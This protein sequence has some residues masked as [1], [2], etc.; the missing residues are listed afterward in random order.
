MLDEQILIRAGCPAG[1]V[2]HCIAVSCT[3]VAI[4]ERITLV[5]VDLEL[6]RTGAL[7]HD[8]GRAR[9]HGLD[10]A[11]VGVELG[12]EIGLPEPVLTIIERHIGAGITANEAGR[13]G[14]PVKDYLPQTPEEKIVSYAD[15]L[16]KGDRPMSFEAALGRFQDILGPGHEGIG[17]FEQQHREIQAWMK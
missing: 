7:L 17:L 3:A 6:V 15:N 9:T 2:A 14:L 8:L 16:T 13:L 1:V 4:A 5:P 12:R 11:I 10:H